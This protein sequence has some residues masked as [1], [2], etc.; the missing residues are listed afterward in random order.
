MKKLTLVILFVA[1]L[2]SFS[3]SNAEKEPTWTYDSIAG[4][5]DVS[6]S[7]D[8]RNISATSGKT[9]SLWLNHTSTPY[10]S[11][12]VGQGITSM[13]MSANGKYVVIAEESD[14]TLT[15]YEEGT[16]EWEKSNF[17]LSVNGVDIT[18]D[19]THLG[20]IDYR[21]VYYF[22]RFSNEAIWSA[23]FGGDVMSSVAISSSSQYLA[24][25]TEDGNVY[26]YDTSSSD[27]VWYYS[28]TLDGKIIDLDF[29]ADSNH[30]V[31][32]TENGKVYIFAALDGELELEYAQPDEVTC[33]SGSSNSNYYAFG[34][35]QGLVTVLDLVDQFL[36]WEKNI[37]GAITEIDFNS[38][39]TY[40]VAGS[41][42]K[43]LLLTNI[44]D[45][46][47]IW[48]T[49]ASAGVTSVSMSY[50]GEN[51]LVG[52]SGGLEL[53]YEQQL[54]NQVPVAI[55]ESINPTTALPGTPITMNGSALD[56]DGFI[57]DYIWISDI[58]GNLSNLSNFTISNLTTGYHIITFQAKDDGGRW[59]R[60][61]TVII[62]VGDFPE[63]SIDSISGCTDF[64]NCVISEG[65]SID[66]VGSA[67]SEASNDTEVVGYQWVSNFSGNE[68][69]ISESD[70]FSTSSLQRGSHTIIF[71]AINDI[72][73]WSSNITANIRINGVPILNSVVVDTNT[74]VAGSSIF[75]V[76]NAQDP[77]GDSLLYIWT[78]SALYFANEQNT[79]ESS[80]NGSSIVT[81]DSD[82]G[83]YEVN[84]HVVD[85]FGASSESTTIT[86]NVLSPPLVL[87]VCQEEVILNEEILFNAIASDKPPGKIVKYEWDFDSS[88]GTIDSVDSTGSAFATHSYN[89]TPPD[90]DFLVV[91][92]VTDDDGLTSRDTCTVTIIKDTL[93]TPKKDS[94]DDGLGSISEIADTSILIGIILIVIIGASVGLYIWNKDNSVTSYL[95]PSKP[96][97]ISG[98]E[99]MSSVVPL[100]SPVKERIV[101]KRKVV[102]ETMTIE[103]PECSAR[104]E[105]PKITGTQQIKCS[106]CG[107][108][109]EIDL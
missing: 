38:K 50:K 2:F 20:V 55:I 86:I 21:N 12:T 35:D 90:S 29:S 25:G 87:A 98:S 108:D 46:D 83:E 36:I 7:E 17:F 104:M 89:S 54:D 28:G 1:I 74:V 39:S 92:R 99:Y 72:G 56:S 48:R 3:S 26:V 8:S 96:E 6:I 44:T 58:D 10:N 27:Y 51:I 4:F 80:D 100:R 69:V 77:D 70:L 93:V 61:V 91:L 107:L 37:G 79:Y 41:T 101:T 59:S 42:N 64:G 24:A 57:V 63:A 19:G 78:T 22:S 32:G 94:S 65:V 43:K 71:R 14:A 88:N 52:T 95:P 34:T 15:L 73:F 67:I 66:F 84:L 40:L 103:C 9:V 53:Y 33:V 82:T 5:T 75:L 60:A 85:S 76:G 49:T 105:I 13:D 81:L 68:T 18:S 23:N 47:E 30:L 31:V 97:P 109:G 45:G 102:T 106:E 62:G 16:K 11:K